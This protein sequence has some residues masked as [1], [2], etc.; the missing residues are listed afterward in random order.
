MKILPPRSTAAWSS[1][2]S[3]IALGLATIR[4]FS[5]GR[6]AAVPAVGVCAGAQTAAANASAP[7]KRL[8]RK[9]IHRLYDFTYAKSRSFGRPTAPPAREAGSSSV[10]PLA[11]LKPPRLQPFS[12]R[13]RLLFRV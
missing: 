13:L 8:N 2:E 3:R 9:V 7:V 6:A 1:L 10:T 12:I 4:P 11:R 5:P